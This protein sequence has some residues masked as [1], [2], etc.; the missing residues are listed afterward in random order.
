MKPP[1]LRRR[2]RATLTP[3]GSGIAYVQDGDVWVED[4]TNGAPRKV[5]DFAFGGALDAI[6]SPDG[7]WVAVTALHDGFMQL[8]DWQR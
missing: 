8:F 3:D 2:V 4:F 6:W 7:R 1:H 5:T